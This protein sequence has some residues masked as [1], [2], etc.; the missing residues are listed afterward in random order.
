MEPQSGE[1]AAGKHR[2]LC[3]LRRVQRLINIKIANAYRTISYDASC[4]MAGV[5]PIAIVIEEKAQLYKS[6]H[7]MEGAA[8]E[9]DMP[10]PVTDWPHPPRRTNILD[11]SDSVSYTAEIYTDCSKIGGKV[12]AGVAIYTD[13]TLVR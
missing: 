9:Y 12:G 6:K 11:T 3:K 13:K 5:Q 2:N 10:V 7:Y 1:E 4:L 8:Y